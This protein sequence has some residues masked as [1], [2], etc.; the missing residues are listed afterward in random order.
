MFTVSQASC[1]DHPDKIGFAHID[2]QCGCDPVI[3]KNKNLLV[4]KILPQKANF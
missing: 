4:F 3:A 1:S 2:M